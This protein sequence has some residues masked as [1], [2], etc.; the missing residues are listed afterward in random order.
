MKELWTMSANSFIKKSVFI[1]IYFFK[2]STFLMKLSTIKYNIFIAIKSLLIYEKN[3]CWMY[4]ISYET[5]YKKNVYIIKTS[6]IIEMW[7]HTY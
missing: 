1:K 5:I 7:T 2:Y 3:A 4:T 6:Y